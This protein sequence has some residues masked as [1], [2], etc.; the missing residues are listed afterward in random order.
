M[1]NFDGPEGFQNHRGYM[2]AHMPEVEKHHH[3]RKHGFLWLGWCALIAALCFAGWQ[4]IYAP[5][6]IQAPLEDHPVPAQELSAPYIDDLVAGAKPEWIRR[7]RLSP[8]P[9]L[10]AGAEGKEAAAFFL[11]SGRILSLLCRHDEAVVEINKCMELRRDEPE[12]LD[13]LGLAYQWAGKYDLAVDSY[14]TAFKAGLPRS[15]SAIHLGNAY[16][17]LGRYREAL[18]E[19][20]L[21]VRFA[22]SPEEKA[23]AYGSLAWTLWN[24]GDRGKAE[25][26]A[27]M[28]ARAPGD[29]SAA[30]NIALFS[31]HVDRAMQ[32]AGVSHPTAASTGNEPG[33][34]A[35]YY[36]L[37]RLSL[38]SGKHEEAIRLFSSALRQTPL[39]ENL[40]PLE[41]CLADAYLEIGW[42][43]QAVDEYRRVLGLNPD[44]PRARYRLAFALQSRGEKA[45]ARIELKRFLSLW[46]GADPDAPQLVGARRRLQMLGD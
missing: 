29:T 42:W 11:E 25:E 20:D 30:F 36:R 26:A 10:P 44:Y 28:E 2:P 40:E 45:A 39:I 37:G 13:D 23:T 18:H 34:R 27:A 7:G 38:R 15:T 22:S 9:S 5:E 46:A 1:I 19:F 41:D 24:M 32:L 33:G 3:R 16:F 21:A 6:S 35:H 14:R 43:D 4:L 31:G 8:V 17:Q 12:V